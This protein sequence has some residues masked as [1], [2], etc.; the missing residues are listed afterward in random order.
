MFV[1][2]HLDYCD[3]IYNAPFIVNEF[4]SLIT[5]PHS[6]ERLERVQYQAALAV[7][8]CWKTTNRNKLY[9][10]LG[11]ESLAYRRWARKLVLFF[12]VLF[13]KSPTYLYELVPP[14]RIPIYGS[15]S[16]HIF[17]DIRFNKNK[18]RDS[19]FPHTTKAWNNL[20]DEFYNCTSISN[21]KHMITSLIRP[22]KKSIFGI[23]DPKGIKFIF[24]LRLGLSPLISH[25]KRHNFLDTPS[26]WCDCLSAPEDTS[27]FILHCT[28]FN[29]SRLKLLNDLNFI[30]FYTIC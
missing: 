13:T 18:Y 4:D 26:D 22:P 12:K 21:F 19:F 16:P 24:Q 23:H 10:E 27:H 9:D 1:R 15:N 29:S 11:W 2:P 3:V 5:L 17:H 8:G 20:S 7:T 14:R 6:M 25:K 30:L 28:K